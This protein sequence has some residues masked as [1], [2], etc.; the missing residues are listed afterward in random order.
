VPSLA[1]ISGKTNPNL[2]HMMRRLT[3]A[4][5]RLLIND[6]VAD[7]SFSTDAQVDERLLIAWRGLSLHSKHEW[8]KITSLIQEINSRERNNG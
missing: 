7:F 6:P 2:G 8:L 4:L 3:I 1:T 5:I